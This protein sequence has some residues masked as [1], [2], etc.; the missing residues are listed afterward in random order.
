MVFT[1]V[2]E[3]MVLFVAAAS[4]IAIGCKSAAPSKS[5][6]A[7]QPAAQTTVT[8]PAKS[9]LLP[10][11]FKVFHVHDGITT[12]VTKEDASD[13][14]IEA[15]LWQLRDAAHGHSLGK[16][17]IDQK[18]VDDRKPMVW[19]HLYRGTRCAAEKYAEGDLPCGNHYNGAGD[20]TYGSYSNKELDRGVLRDG[21]KETQ[22]WD[23]EKVYV[24]GS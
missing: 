20:Y 4:S 3:K 15:I 8:Y 18:M 11:T 2:V 22:L 16:L 9:T 1:R 10:P 7:Q 14:E 6:E 21:E 19:F 13:A 23:P 17:K 5:V 24:K 12:L